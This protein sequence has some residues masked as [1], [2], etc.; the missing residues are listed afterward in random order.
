MRGH[1]LR[2]YAVSESFLPD[3]RVLWPDLLGW[4]AVGMAESVYHVYSPTGFDAYVRPDDGSAP[5]L[6]RLKARTTVPVPEVLDAQPGWLLLKALPGI[7]LHDAAVW[8]ERP[9]D[10]TRI[11]AAA[12]RA[13]QHTGVTHGDMCLPNILGNPTTGELTGIV[14]WRYA[15]QLDREIDVA[16]AVWSCEFNGYDDD[17]AV[18]VLRACGWPYPDTREVRRL[19]KVWLDQSPPS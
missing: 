2:S 18:E 17:V 19:R 8:R 3:P 5:L 4:E 7:P 11:V 13:L 1:E 6:R 12:L 16:A 15:E 14:D 9:A 10:V